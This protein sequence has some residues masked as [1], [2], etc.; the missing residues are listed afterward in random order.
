MK[1]SNVKRVVTIVAILSMCFNTTILFAEGNNVRPNSDN[2]IILP[3]NIAIAATGN[4]LTLV[5][6]GKFYCFG[7]TE[8]ISGYSAGVV[9]ELQQLNGSWQT[10]KDWSDQNTYYAAIEDDYYVSK[11]YNYRLKLTHTAYNS[12]GTLIETITKYSDVVYY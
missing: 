8:V 10:I 2:E 12:Y 4:E 1:K 3:M 9:V 5:S 7:E 6:A 11:G